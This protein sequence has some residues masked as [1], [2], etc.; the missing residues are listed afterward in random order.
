[1]ALVLDIAAAL[2]RMGMTQAGASVA[3]ARMEDGL[4]Q[5]L[6]LRRNDG[7]VAT[8]VTE[9]LVAHARRIFAELRHMAADIAARPGQVRGTVV[10]ALRPSDQCHGL[11]TE[12]LFV[13]RLAILARADHPP[14]RRAAECR[15]QAGDRRDPR[16]IAAVAVIPLPNCYGRSF[17]ST[18]MS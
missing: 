4:G 17:I 2:Y 6:F 5:T 3:L 16:R 18:R 9:R 1:V 8:D 11:I 10:G 14:A 7:M 12:P 13:D 15:V